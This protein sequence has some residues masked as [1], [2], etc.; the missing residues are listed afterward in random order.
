MKN[1]VWAREQMARDHCTNATHLQE[2]QEGMISDAVFFFLCSLNQVTVKE[3][4]HL[5]FVSVSN[6]RP[7]GNTRLYDA[8]TQAARTHAASCS[9]TVDTPITR[10]TSSSDIPDFFISAG[11]CSSDA[12]RCGCPAPSDCSSEPSS[13]LAVSV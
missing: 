13:L 12:S 4:I 11:G 10:R 7:L 6:N 8:K 9:A 3:Q 5:F 1:G 2:L